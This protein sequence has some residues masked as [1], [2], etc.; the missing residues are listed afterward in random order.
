[1]PNIKPTSS[2]ERLVHLDALRG[3]ALLGVLLVNLLTFFRVSLFTQIVAGHTHPGRA[4]ALVDEGV[5][6]L[7]E[8]KAFTLFSLL[9]GVGMGI[10]ADRLP[11]RFLLRRFLVLLGIGF[12]HLVLVSNVDIL[13]LYAL[14]GLLLLPLVK[15]PTPPQRSPAW[16]CVGPMKKGRGRLRAWFCPCAN[17]AP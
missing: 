10:Q 16:A 12:C 14:C 9:F 1:M 11:G 3:I 8:F 17:C 15:L 6:V 13:C 5:T 4:N 7:L 2:Q